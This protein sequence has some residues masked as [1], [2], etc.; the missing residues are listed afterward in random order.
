M[1][2]PSDPPY[3]GRARRR[4]LADTARLTPILV[5]RGHL[6]AQDGQ[7]QQKENTRRRKK[8]NV[9]TIFFQHFDFKLANKNTK[10]RPQ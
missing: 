2:T 3:L 10:T 6:R 1:L 7:M 4:N 5:Q 9:E 8:I